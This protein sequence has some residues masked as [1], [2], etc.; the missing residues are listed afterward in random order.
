MATSSSMIHAVCLSVCQSACMSVCVY[1][2]ECVDSPQVSVIPPV[3]SP[4]GDD[5]TLSLC[6]SVGPSIV[7][8]CFVCVCVNV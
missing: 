5:V 3:S 2:C 7:C 4:P 1:V 8:V 6:L